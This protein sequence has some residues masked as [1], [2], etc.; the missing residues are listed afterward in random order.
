M[1]RKTHYRNTRR[2]APFASDR[3]VEDFFC[4]RVL[5]RRASSA[6][7][8]T[9]IESCRRRGIGPHA[10]LK[11]QLV[12]TEVESSLERKLIR[13]NSLELR[14]LLEGWGPPTDV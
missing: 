10:Y 13:K 2:S 3:R 11:E 7:R 5:V 9:V 6:A 1:F 14:K 8:S 12:S 4:I